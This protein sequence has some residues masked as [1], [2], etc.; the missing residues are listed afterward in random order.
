[1]TY[2]V[3]FKLSFHCINGICLLDWCKNL[4][5][6]EFC[7]RRRAFQANYWFQKI[8]RELS[9]VL[10]GSSCLSSWS[11]TF[12]IDLILRSEAWKYSTWR[13]WISI[14]CRFWSFMNHSKRRNCKK[15]LWHCWVS[16]SWN[17]RWI[18][19]WLCNRLV[20]FRDFNLWNAC[21]DSSLLP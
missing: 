15:F 1:M 10:C 20:G 4:L 2:F 21:W 12:L 16:R 19:A 18:R 7:Q 3:N 6:D 17:D 5:F 11:S 8:S 9:E 13:R 14:P